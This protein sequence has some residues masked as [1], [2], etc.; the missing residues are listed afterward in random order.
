VAVAIA[1][2]LPRPIS[3]DCGPAGGDPG[4]AARGARGSPIPGRAR[5]AGRNPALARPRARILDRMHDVEFVLISLLV[6]VAG[7]AAAARAVNIP[8]PIVL[9]V[10]GLVLGF[11]PGL[12]DVHL[13]PDLV[14]V[15]FLPPLLYSAAFFANLNELRRD[16][17]GISLLAVGLVLATMCAVALVAHALIDGLSWAAA[18]TLGAIVAPTDPLAATAI[19]RRQNAPRRVVSVIEGESL[20][21]DGT[22]LV[23]Y[24][25]AAAATLW[26]GFSLWDAGLEFVLDASGGVLIGLA[27]GFLI[28]ELRN[29]LD[30]I[31]VEITV[32][33]LSGYAAYLPAEAAGVSGVLAAVTTGVVVGWQAPR[34]STAS[35]RLQGFAVWETLVFL[36]NALLFVLIGLQLPLIIDGLSGESALTLIGQAAAISVTV[37]LAR[38]VWMQTVVFVIRALDRRPQQRARR[39]DWR[40][41]LIIGWSGMRGAVSLAAALALS[42]D[43]PQRN[44]VQLMT[45]AVILTT[46]VIQGLTLPVLIRRLG[47]HDDG[48]EER[49]ELTGRRAAV[50]VAL[51]RIE[52]LAA[53]EWTREDTVERMRM[54]YEYRGRRLASRAGESDDGEDYEHRARKYQMM[55]REVL[56]A[57]RAE[58]A[59][60]R[61]SGTI[62][63]EVMHRLERELD[64]EDERL[65]I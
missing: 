23:A 19:A 14:L 17:R 8:Y 59:R 32:S 30:D 34:I 27:V 4:G 38:I 6:A 58:L 16:L 50:D 62:S 28:A 3:I 48:S 47:V 21:N 7:L 65:E 2:I 49:E 57:Q 61:N 12:P 13:E 29:R 20:I 41:R 39:G 36:L 56:D 11:V 43:F 25:T 37:V 63:N 31:P 54:A 18:F 42:P 1:S 44:V 10:G 46:L 26:G 60:L 35:M 55:V 51:S 33:L 64:L 5:T 53:E 24:K 15:L 9:V 22:A 45:F 40:S 52:E